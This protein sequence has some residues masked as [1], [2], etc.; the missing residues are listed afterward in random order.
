VKAAL[1][2]TALSAVAAH[3]QPAPNSLLPPVQPACVSSPFGDR[4]A[5]GPHAIGFHNGIDLPAPAGAAIYAAAA[6]QIVSIHRG[7]PGGLE[8]AILH[9][10]P[11]GPYTTLYAH[12]GLIAPVFARG[13]SRVAAG[14]RIAVVGRSGVIY[15][16]HLFFEVLVKGRPIDP[17]GPLAV[18]F[19]VKTAFIN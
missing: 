3:A 10:G 18:E 15:G 12:L 5:P 8:M 13:R 1:L 2:L 11:N 7:G 19:C 9:T 17:V 16:T 6:G 4:K 14:E